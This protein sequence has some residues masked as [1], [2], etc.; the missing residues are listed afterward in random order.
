[1][2][3]L[4]NKVKAAL[5]HDDTPG[6]TNAG[7]HHSNAANSADPRVDSDR[8]HGGYSAGTGHTSGV[9]T[10]VGHTGA[11]SGAGYGT[12][13]QSG[14]YGSG[15]ATMGS[16]NTMHSSRAANKLDP[17]V[18][19][20]FDH[21]ANPGSNVGGYGNTQSSSGYGGPAHAAHAPSTTTAGHHGNNMHSNQ[22]GNKM[23]P[24]VDSDFDHRGNP[25]SHVGG[26]GNQETARY[27]G[28]ASGMPTD[29][30]AGHKLQSGHHGHHGHQGQGTTGIHDQVTT[31]TTMGTSTHG[32]H[33]SGAQTGYQN[34]SGTSTH[35]PH[36][37]NLLN[38]VD[39]R[40]KHDNEGRPL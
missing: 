28:G 10:G 22:L 11:H 34:T 27:G 24:R 1:M 2:S 39:P 35:A 9:S 5:S 37:S 36:N 29:T 19:S 18:D 4:M 7:P 17:R 21:R 3:G 31:H 38:K 8:S 23:D 16:G 26:Y 12:G 14:E 20:D 6:S 13:P 33:N 32:L 40:V 25:G 15:A 30:P